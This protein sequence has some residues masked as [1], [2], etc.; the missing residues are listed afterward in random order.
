MAKLKNFP[1][2]RG[3]SGR[4]AK[5]QWSPKGKAR[6][7]EQEAELIWAKRSAGTWAEK[8]HNRE[9]AGRKELGEAIQLAHLAKLLARFWSH[10]VGVDVLQV[11]E[12]IQAFL[13]HLHAQ[14]GLYATGR[15]QRACLVHT[16]W[17]AFAANHA[18]AALAPLLRPHRHTPQQKFECWVRYLCATSLCVGKVGICTCNTLPGTVV[19]VHIHTHEHTYVS[20]RDKCKYTHIRMIHRWWVTLS[21]RWWA[22]RGHQVCLS[23]RGRTACHSSVIL[24]RYAVHDE[25]GVAPP[26]GAWRRRSGARG[27]PPCMD[28]LTPQD[29]LIH[30]MTAQNRHPRVENRVQAHG[31]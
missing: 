10:L 23:S 16:S 15:Q 7:R 22:R 31:R 18:A 14:Y 1:V 13:K 6:I 20:H 3:N 29:Q 21:V 26:G 25:N 4:E 17:T 24:L 19:Y 8:F 2:Q 27:V 9:G 5:G 12:L 28:P 30:C 11:L